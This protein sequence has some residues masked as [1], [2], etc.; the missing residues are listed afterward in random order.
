MLHD[1]KTGQEAGF[2]DYVTK[3]IRIDR[4]MEV[5]NRA[6]EFAANGR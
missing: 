4:F 5:M 1:V 3:P 6:F 2:F